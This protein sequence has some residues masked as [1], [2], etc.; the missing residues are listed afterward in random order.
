MSAPDPAARFAALLESP[1]EA[2]SLSPGE[3]YKII[4]AAVRSKLG[5]ADRTIPA[6]TLHA[7]VREVTFNWVTRPDFV[8]SSEWF[9]ARDHLADA[10]LGL[11]AYVR[12]FNPSPASSP[13]PSPAASYSPT[14]SQLHP[15]SDVD[16]NYLRRLGFD[17]DDYP[18][19]FDRA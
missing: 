12:F 19:L 9:E 2:E 10:N 16:S 8:D 18:E 15:D 14:S 7:F 13:A 4:E 11:E 6:S 1:A 5:H 3:L 17:S